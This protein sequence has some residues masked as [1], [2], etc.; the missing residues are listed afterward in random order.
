M[1]T[2]AGRLVSLK[3]PGTATAMVKEACSDLG[4]GHT[5]FQ[6]TSASKQA[7]DPDTAVIVYVDDAEVTDV[8]T[9]A[10]DY[11]LGK[12]TFSSEKNGHTVTISG[13]YLPLLDFLEVRSAEIVSPQAVFADCTRLGDAADRKVEVC[14]KCS[15]KTEPFTVPSTDLDT[16]AGTT[17]FSTLLAADKFFVEC[18]VSTVQT[19]RGWFAPT[20]TAKHAL[21]DAYV[22]TL[23]LVGVVQSPIGRPSTDQALFSVV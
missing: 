16:G 13:K 10:V 2:L 12:I 6:I 5:V 7:I 23:D 22:G 19:V 3:V 11:A 8:T 9:Y 17:L 15:I 21:N 1:A 4:G 14:K 20:Y 18:K